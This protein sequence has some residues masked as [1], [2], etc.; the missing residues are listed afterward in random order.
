MDHNHLWG[1]LKHKLRDT[2]RVPD[3]V[4]LGWDLRMCILTSSQVTSMMLVTETQET[5][6][7]LR[8]CLGRLVQ[9]RAVS[10]TGILHGSP[11]SEEVIINKIER[12]CATRKVFLA[13]KASV[14]Q[15]DGKRFKKQYASMIL[16][17]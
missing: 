13:M 16:I 3:P 17:Y 9:Q 5:Q 7:E 6:H 2:P 4:S 12:Q 1:L 8:S 15:I 14:F 10:T 11:N